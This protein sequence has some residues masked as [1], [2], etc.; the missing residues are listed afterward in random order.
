MFSFFLRFPHVFVDGF[1]TVL[2]VFVDGFPV[3]EHG[4]NFYAR[5]ANVIQ[6]LRLP[7]QILE[8]EEQ[9]TWQTLSRSC[10]PV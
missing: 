6:K 5:V 10:H 8:S 4:Y 7:R 2:H 9:I 1:V 3:Q